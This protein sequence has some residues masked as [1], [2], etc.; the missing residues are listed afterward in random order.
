MTI[1]ALIPRADDAASFLKALASGPRLLIL[2]ALANGERSVGALAD[3]TGLRLPA[4]SQNLALLKA[5]D[6]VASRREGTTIY[7]SL[8]DDAAKGIMLVLKDRFCPPA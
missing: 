3:E 8:T 4:V 5:E 2:C 7:Y 1:N 6:I